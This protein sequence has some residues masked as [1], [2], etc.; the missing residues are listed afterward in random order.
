M[1]RILGVDGLALMR[2]LGLS[3]AS[4]M[5]LSKAHGVTV[6][7]NSLIIDPLTILPPPVIR[8]TLTRVRISGDQ[9]VQ[10]IGD[11]DAV[12]PLRVWML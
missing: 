1:Q 12:V 4:M 5:D 3:L 11:S 10:T 9:L 6:E 2:A 8:G 7:R